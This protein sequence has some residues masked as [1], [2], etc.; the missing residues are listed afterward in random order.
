MVIKQENYLKVRKNSLF[1]KY[2]L[3]SRKIN[4]ED[5]LLDITVV[6]LNSQDK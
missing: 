3:I 2:S 1:L 5:L 6:F 4:F